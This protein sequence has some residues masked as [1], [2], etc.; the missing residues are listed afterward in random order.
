VGGFPAHGLL[1]DKGTFT[2]L[3]RVSFFHVFLPLLN[4]ELIEL[5]HRVLRVLY[6]PIATLSV[7]PKICGEYW[8]LNL[9]K[10]QV[11]LRF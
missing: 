1:T 6:H 7:N 5:A 11:A 2:D 4:D 10:R 8:A 9:Q 3:W